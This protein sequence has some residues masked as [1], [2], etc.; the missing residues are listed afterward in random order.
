LWA[1][2]VGDGG[3]NVGSFAEGDVRMPNRADK[4]DL[5]CDGMGKEHR[6]PLVKV[7]CMTNR[8][9]Q[10][11]KRVWRGLGGKPPRPKSYK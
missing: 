5:S 9:Y 4:F 1:G 11:V 6:I 7:R 3:S 8:C 2:V 10:E